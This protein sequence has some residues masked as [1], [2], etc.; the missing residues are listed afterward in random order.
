VDSKIYGR[1]K[2]GLISGII[3]VF[4]SRD[5]REPIKGEEL[6]PEPSEIERVL[7]TRS[8]LSVQSLVCDVYLAEF[9]GCLT[10]ALLNALFF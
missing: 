4:A 7:S 8:R 10:S 6:N 3:F 1:K 9:K 5:R 2:C